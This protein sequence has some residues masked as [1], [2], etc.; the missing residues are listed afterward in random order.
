MIRLSERPGDFKVR[1]A[2]CGAESSFRDWPHVVYCSVSG[3][4][5]RLCPGC[6]GE[7]P[8]IVADEDPS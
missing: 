5:A 7:R 1:C 6:G 8:V 3:E 2:D 4:G